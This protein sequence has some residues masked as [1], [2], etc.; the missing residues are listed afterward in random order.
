[1]HGPQ[2]PYPQQPYSFHRYPQLQPPR[3]KRTGLII[4]AVIGALVLVGGGVTAAVLVTKDEKPAAKQ[5]AGPP[6]DDVLEETISAEAVKYGDMTVIDACTLMSAAVLEET[7]FGDVAHGMH[8]Q[9]YVE[10]SVPTAEATVKDADDGISICRYD[11]S[12]PG[13]T[14]M[15][16]LSVEQRPFND[17]LPAYVIGDDIEITVGGL[18]AFTKKPEGRKPDGFFTRIYSADGRTAVHLNAARLADNK[19]LDYKAAHAKLL[20]R[21]ATNLAKAPQDQTRYAYTG[22]YENVPSACDILT[23]QL[24][25]ELAQAKDSGVVQTE[26][27]DGEGRQDSTPKATNVTQYFYFTSQMCQRSSPAHLKLSKGVSLKMQLDVFRDADMA[28]NYEPDCDPNSTSRR[29]L[30]DARTATEKVGDGDA[31]AFPIGNSLVFSY[32]AG[33]A[34]VRLTPYGSWAPKDVDE[35]IAKFTPIAQKTVDE[36]RKAIG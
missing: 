28:R 23:G 25:E 13:R 14:E 26:I 2:Q 22:R 9:T 17:P 20:E 21:I 1:M 3:R 7:G 32:L 33:R 16:V 10:K 31:C 5:E 34:Q 19:D 24:F 18:K 15:L 30:G 4:T 36:V 35:F 6:D 27:N 11:A 12:M 8:S 29:L